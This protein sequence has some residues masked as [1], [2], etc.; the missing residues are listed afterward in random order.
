MSLDEDKDPG[1]PSGEFEDD[2]DDEDAS[3]EEEEE[4]V[5][6][7]RKRAR[8]SSDTEELGTS[9]THFPPG[10]GAPKMVEPLRSVPPESGTSGHISKKKKF[11][12]F[13]VSS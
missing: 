5:L 8:E 13:S 1:F 3:E 4:G 11:A 7:T 10:A 6:D 2:G 12:T 9:S